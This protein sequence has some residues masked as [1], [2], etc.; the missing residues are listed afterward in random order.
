VLNRRKRQIYTPESII[1]FIRCKLCA[2]L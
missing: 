1:I 2:V